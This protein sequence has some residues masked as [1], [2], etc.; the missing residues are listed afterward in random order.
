MEVLHE[1]YQTDEEME[2]AKGCTRIIT[3]YEMFF[4]DDKR[5]KKSPLLAVEHNFKADENNVS[6]EEREI[7]KKKL[8]DKVYR[9]YNIAEPKNLQLQLF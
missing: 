7:I 5:F 6:L 4:L 2:D 8:L 9:F 1:R 3:V